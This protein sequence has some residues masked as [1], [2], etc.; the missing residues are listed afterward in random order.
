M[1]HETAAEQLSKAAKAYRRTE[2]AHEEARQALKQAA[3]EALDAGVKQS[4]VVKTTGWTRE[5]LRR[6]RK[7]GDGDAPAK[8]KKS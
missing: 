6:L 5:Y 7:G 4:E 3:V 8:P 1:E 2:K